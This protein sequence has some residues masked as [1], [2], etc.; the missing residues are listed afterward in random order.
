MHNKKRKE[1]RKHKRPH[2]NDRPLAAAGPKPPPNTT[3]SIQKRSP[4]AR[5]LRRE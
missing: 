2:H 3:P 4:K 5:P 1:K